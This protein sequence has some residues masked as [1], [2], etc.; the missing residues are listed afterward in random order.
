M[1]SWSW[2]TT[3]PRVCQ[4]LF[5]NVLVLSHNTYLRRSLCSLKQHIK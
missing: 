4:L 2:K 1:T 3:N 5:S